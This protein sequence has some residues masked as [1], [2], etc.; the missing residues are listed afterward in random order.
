M[1]SSGEGGGGEGGEPF[2]GRAAIGYD[3]G[4]D[5]LKSSTSGWPS[6]LLVSRASPTGYHYRL[7]YL[8]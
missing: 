4:Y 2:T 7:N 1:G 5:A 6:A 3:H 8:E